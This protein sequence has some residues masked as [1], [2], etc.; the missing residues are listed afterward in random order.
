MGW[1]AGGVMARRK[2]GRDTG[3][4]KKD[5][6]KEGEREEGRDTQTSS[7]L[8]AAE[9]VVTSRPSPRRHIKL[10]SAG[11]LCRAPLALRINTLPRPRKCSIRLG[12]KQ[13]SIVEQ[14]RDPGY[15]LFRPGQEHLY[16]VVPI[17]PSPMPSPTPSGG[18]KSPDQGAAPVLKH[19]ATAAAATPAQPQLLLL[20]R[21]HHHRHHHRH[22]RNNTLQLPAQTCWS[23]LSMV[24]S[25]GC[26]AGCS[27]KRRFGSLESSVQPDTKIF[28]VGGKGWPGGEREGVAGGEVENNATFAE[29]KLLLHPQSR[30]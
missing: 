3:G 30:R 22:N 6:E 28:R 29:K 1:A 13:D 27:T 8:R 24:K 12:Q 20:L 19:D 11:R 25:G 14:I 9:R 5:Q 7:R 16:N 21:R 17:I 15:R 4:T 18:A 26:R 23:A 2:Q 10:P